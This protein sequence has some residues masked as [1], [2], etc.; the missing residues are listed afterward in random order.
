MSTF[1]HLRRRLEPLALGVAIFAFAPA[2]ATLA[3]EA[4]APAATDPENEGRPLDG[5]LGTGILAGLAMWA[6]GKTAR[7]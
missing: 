7:R 4:A 1:S 5:Y 2:P 3:Q 6:V